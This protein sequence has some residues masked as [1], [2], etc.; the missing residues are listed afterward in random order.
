MAGE[1]R[2]PIVEFAVENAQTLK[3]R[4]ASAAVAPCRTAGRP[5]TEPMPPRVRRRS[6]QVL[7]QGRAAGAAHAADASADG[8]G[9]KRGTSAQEA[10]AGGTAAGCAPLPACLLTHE[11]AVHHLLLVRCWSCP[12]RLS[13]VMRSVCF[14]CR[15]KRRRRQRMA[16]LS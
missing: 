12:A 10:Q 15:R 4:S 3:K 14:V 1:E 16:V 5:R 13:L 6:G 7:T 8:A 2:R 11:S 9:A